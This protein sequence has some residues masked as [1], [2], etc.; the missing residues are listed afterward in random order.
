MLIYGYISNSIY[1]IESIEQYDSN[2]IDE[3]VKK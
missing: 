2:L 3:L 1:D